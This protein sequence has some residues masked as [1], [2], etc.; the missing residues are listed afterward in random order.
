MEVGREE[1]TVAACGQ[2]GTRARRRITGGGR[3]GGGGQD[4]TGGARREGTAAAWGQDGMRAPSRGSGEAG[5]DGRGARMRPGAQGWEPRVQVLG[6]DRWRWRGWVCVG[7]ERQMNSGLVKN[8][9]SV[10]NNAT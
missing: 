7:G 2:D 3:R 5:R 10:G 1:R 8:S 6:R 4:G 9:I